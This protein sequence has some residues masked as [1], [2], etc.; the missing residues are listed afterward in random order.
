MFGS[1]VGEP[2]YD[3]RLG[4]YRSLEAPWWEAA[5]PQAAQLL[6]HRCLADL[7]NGEDLPLRHASAQALQQLVEACVKAPQGA[8]AAAADHGV[9]AE[10]TEEE[11]EGVGRDAASEQPAKTG[12]ELLHHCAGSGLT[13]WAVTRYPKLPAMT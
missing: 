2:D 7:R 5:S 9:A 6:V 3:R 13:C 10:G 1:Q 4:A 12:S 8:V 11:Q